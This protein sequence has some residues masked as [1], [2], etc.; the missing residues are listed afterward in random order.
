MALHGFFE[1]QSIELLQ[2]PCTLICG[3]NS[4]LSCSPLLLIHRILGILSVPQVYIF[5]LYL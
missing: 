2:L 5:S 3:V 1:Y 4:H